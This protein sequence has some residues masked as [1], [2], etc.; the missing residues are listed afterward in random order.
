MIVIALA[1]L[2][3]RISIHEIVRLSIQ[4]NQSAAQNTLKLISI[5]M[6]NYSKNN[7]GVYAENFLQLTQATPAYL[8]RN[9]VKDSPVRGYDY[10]CPRMDAAGYSCIASPDHCRLSGEAVYSVSTGGL[11]ISESCDKK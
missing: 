8:G 2:A 11:F 6:E 10:D 4:Q 3:L 9:Y 5:A 1:A 7:K